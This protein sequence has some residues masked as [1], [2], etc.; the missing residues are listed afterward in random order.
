MKK[1]L[2]LVLAAVV[3]LM[4]GI[5][6]VV[7][8]VGGHEPVTGQKLVGVGP[9]GTVEIGP[10]PITRQA[11]FQFTNPDCIED[12]TITKVSVMENGNGDVIYEGP[13]VGVDTEGAEVVRT[14]I[15]ELAPHDVR[16]IRLWQ[17]MWI[18]PDEIS[19]LD[20]LEDNDNWKETFPAFSQ[21]LIVCTVEIEWEA[22]GSACPLTGWVTIKDKEV[23][24]GDEFRHE[25][26]REM[27]NLKQKK[28]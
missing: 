11:S 21:D 28:E 13:F 4:A 17:Y 15:T 19:D 12:I 10:G 23:R 24:W 27:V 22:A 1:K 16:G 18:G 26:G 20:E 6:G 9:M 8:A 5:G 25:F 7:Y 2:V 14:V 3:L